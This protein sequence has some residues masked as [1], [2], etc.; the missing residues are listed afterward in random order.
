MAFYFVLAEL[1]VN[2]MA[3]WTNGLAPNLKKWVN[4]MKR[5]AQSLNSDLL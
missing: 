4:Q 3:G 5:I 2:E 1:L